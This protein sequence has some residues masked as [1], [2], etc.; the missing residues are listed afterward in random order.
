MTKPL[1]LINGIS[2]RYA[3]Q[4]HVPMVAKQVQW[5]TL[6]VGACWLKVSYIFNQVNVKL[7]LWFKDGKGT[8]DI[9][10]TGLVKIR[11][12][13]ECRTMY[14]KVKTATIT[15]RMLC[16][17][18]EHGGVDTCAGDSGGPL[19]VMEDGYYKICGITSFGN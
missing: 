4:S 16:A 17:N 10:Q 15:D 5:P 13:N 7:L 12:I 8:P 6:L 1:S 18:V 3:C 19:M 9:M 2:N 11:D 14:S